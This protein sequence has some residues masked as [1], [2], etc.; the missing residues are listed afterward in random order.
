MQDL[1]STDPTQETCARSCRSCN[2]V[3]TRQHELDHT[4]HADHTRSGVDDVCMYLPRK[5]DYLPEVC[6]IEN[7]MSDPNVLGNLRVAMVHTMVEVPRQQE[8]FGL[9]YAIL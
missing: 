2:T 1:F 3:P 9:Y 4:D 6:T 8:K 7:S 5:I